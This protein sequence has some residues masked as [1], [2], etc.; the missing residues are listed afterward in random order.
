[1]TRP[2][3]RSDR[4]V[5]V[6][7]HSGT[8][9]PG[10]ALLELLVSAAVVCVLLGV[11]IRFC[12]MAQA[13]VRTQGDRADLQQR[14][15]VAVEALR[16]DLMA[17]G[18]GLS[19]GLPRG[20]LVDVFAPVLPARSGRSGADLEVSYH[21]DRI[22]IIYVPAGA[23]QTRLAQAMVADDGPLLIDSNAPGCP[24]GNLCGFNR[25][26]RVLVYASSAGDGSYDVFT[27]SGA[28]A[29][30]AL[31]IPD[32][33]L[34]RAYPADSRI[35][36]IV[37]RVY[38]LDRAGRRLMVYDGDRSDV[39]LVDHVV[40]LQFTYFADPAPTSVT[41]PAEGATNCAYA[42]GPP[43]VPVLT[44]LGGTALV[45][46]SAGQLTDGPVCGLAPRRFDVDLMRV[47]RIGVSLRLE[48]EGAE[49][50]GSGPSF[51]NP[52]TSRDADR[53][54]PDLQVTFEVAPRNM[55]NTGL[56]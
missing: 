40:D 29:T 44:D 33:P 30:Q 22:S 39:P 56:R 5:R 3:R 47:R 19:S 13:S 1:M 36:T 41:P 26:D 31:L 48:T 54:I 55:L 37:Q 4:D 15:R 12:V 53:Y 23:S 52:G 49:F 21:A 27:V 34:S 28:D 38:Y 9:A 43:P 45:P 32:A 25:G 18:A 2:D 35:A 7:R 10:Y 11:L 51:A 16:R 17:A 24:S 6:R 42:S 14:L 46:L 50:R 8:G 20:P